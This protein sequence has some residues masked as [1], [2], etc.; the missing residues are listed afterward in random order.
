MHSVYIQFSL[1][2]SYI[3]FLHTFVFLTSGKQK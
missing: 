1:S 3:L 2:N